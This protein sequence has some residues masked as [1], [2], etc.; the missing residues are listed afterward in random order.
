MPHLI[1]NPVKPQLSGRHPGLH[2]PA[3]ESTEAYKNGVV[4]GCRLRFGR[5]HLVG[6]GARHTGECARLY[7]QNPDNAKGDILEY[8]KIVYEKD[9][10][11]E[12]R[13]WLRLECRL[14]AEIVRGIIRPGTATKKEAQCVAW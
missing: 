9:R 8:M 2:Q 12:D 11:G 4:L 1:H 7:G 13:L 3:P 10:Y 5:I 6:G 14:D